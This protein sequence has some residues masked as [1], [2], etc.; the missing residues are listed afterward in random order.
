MKFQLITPAVDE[1]ISLEEA[2][3]QVGV[4]HDADDA[5]LAGFISAAREY[6]EEKCGM[7]LMPSVWK[8]FIEEF[9]ED[10]CIY[11]P[12]YPLASVESVIYYPATGGP[13]SLPTSIYEVDTVSVPPE[14][15]LA[16]WKLWPVSVLRSVNGVEINFTAG[17]ESAAAVPATLK[18]AMKLIIG[19][20]YQNR[21]S[22]VTERMVT[23]TMLPMGVD[24]LTA[25]YR[26]YSKS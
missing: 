15:E 24:A 2:R 8:G 16:P 25:N 3:Q 14:I 21:E 20:L 1:P 17:Y 9:P 19:H 10:D 22:V 6:V 13:V 18:A 26:I 4:S 11:I 5:L 12:K 23:P 7:A